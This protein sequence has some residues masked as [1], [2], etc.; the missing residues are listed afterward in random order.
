MWI[1]GTQLVMRMKYRNKT[2]KKKCTWIK[3]KSMPLI[4]G[5]FVGVHNCTLETTDSAYARNNKWSFGGWG[6]E[7][8][9]MF[10]VAVKCRA[11]APASWAKQF[12]AMSKHMFTCSRVFISYKPI[13]LVWDIISQKHMPTLI[14][15]LRM[16]D[17][18]VN[19]H[20]SRFLFSPIRTRNSHS[21]YMLIMWTLI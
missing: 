8:P 20:S 21:T 19:Q 13:M 10:R 16:H 14:I 7:N 4:N 6:E 11:R 1:I 3:R 18:L 2:R 12:M 5:V 9:Y 17:L 15:Y